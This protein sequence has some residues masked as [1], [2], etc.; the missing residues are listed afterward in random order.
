MPSETTR[1]APT[2]AA[3]S[4]DTRRVRFGALRRRL[5]WETLGLPLCVLVLGWVFWYLTPNFL[6]G[7]N[8]ANV[9][10]QIA[11]LVLVSSGMAMV[12]LTAGI[13][14]SVGSV[15]ALVSVYS[16]NAL[17]GHGVVA[18]I[19]VGL[20]VG[21]LAGLVNGILV[22]YVGLPAFIATLGML[23]VARGIAL[24]KTGG[25]PIFDL[26]ESNIFWIGQGNFAG[27]PAPLLFA[28]VG[29]AL[30]WILLYRTAFGRYVYAIGGHEESARL[31]GIPVARVKLYVYA[32][33]GLLTGLGGLLLTARVKSGQPTLGQGLELQAIAA[34]VIG[35][36]ALEGGRG[37]LV[38]VLW[39]VVFIG[40]LGNGLNLVGVSTF[41]QQIVIG[42]V[43]VVAVAA[44]VIVNRWAR[45]RS[46]WK[47][48]L[49]RVKVR[50]ASNR[51]AVR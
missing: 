27:V 18:F 9:G 32:W 49:G 22:G 28:A 3:T 8:L 35:G 33:T 45:I 15:V 36:V 12:I 5:N 25:V 23:S 20:G 43:T 37:R 34:V 26:P 30:T 40:L 31:A 7:S 11:V 39:G 48:N 21:L 24:T 1:P 6:T 42:M 17:A 19:A 46:W 38:G 44:T 4:S 51:G 29:A 10:R 2:G 50:G 41:V 14:L 16:A 47:V 13:D